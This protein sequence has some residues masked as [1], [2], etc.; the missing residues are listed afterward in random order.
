LPICSLD[1]A[2]DF[3]GAILQQKPQ[4]ETVLIEPDMQRVQL[5]WRTGIQVD[6]QLLKLR[7]VVVNC[8]EYPLK[9]KEAA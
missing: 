7:E 4:L 2:F 3:N 5:L 9:V 8:L 6:K 1:L